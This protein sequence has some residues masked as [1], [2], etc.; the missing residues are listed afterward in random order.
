MRTVLGAEPWQ[1]DTS[2]RSSSWH[3][4]KSKIQH[5]GY[6]RLKVGVMWHDGVVHPQPPISRA[7]REVVRKLKEIEEIEVFDWL[8]YKHDV[9]WDITVSSGSTWTEVSRVLI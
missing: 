6:K 8:P 4:E 2:L 3:D 5:N 7:L 9:A 1:E